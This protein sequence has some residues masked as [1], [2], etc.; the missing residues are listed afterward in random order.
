MKNWHA[1]NS[2]HFAFDAPVRRSPSLKK[3]S[4]SIFVCVRGSSSLLGLFFIKGHFKLM[5][6][7]VHLKS[8]CPKIQSSAKF[9][10]VGNIKNAR[11]KYDFVR[12]KILAR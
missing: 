4:Y 1:G 5:S 12:S 9:P 3:A 8:R 11:L 10:A 2:V 6:T 7:I